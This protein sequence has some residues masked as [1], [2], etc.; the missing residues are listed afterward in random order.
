M[1][2]I[3]ATHNV[4]RLNGSLQHLNSGA[5]NPAVR[6]YGGTRP[7]T[8][9]GVPTSEMLTEIPLTQPAG[10]I[11]NAALKL[12]QSANG[13]IVATGAPTWARFVNGDGDTCFDAD[14]GFGAGDWEVEL[15]KATLYAGGEVMLMSAELT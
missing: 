6:I 5:G 11:E 10:V 7:E 15:D 4:F 2:T 1:I 9:S 3:T 12:T 13:F 8:A 14:A